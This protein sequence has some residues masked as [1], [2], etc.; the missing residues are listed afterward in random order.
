MWRPP[1]GGRSTNKD[2]TARRQSDG[3]DR[4]VGAKRKPHERLVVR[5]DA[6]CSWV[7]ELCNDRAALACSAI[8]CTSS[9]TRSR[10]RRENRRRD[11]ASLGWSARASASSG[12][13]RPCADGSFGRVGGNGLSCWGT[14]CRVGGAVRR[15]P[16]SRFVRS[17]RGGAVCRVEGSGGAR[18]DDGSAP[19][20]GREGRPSCSRATSAVIQARVARPR[21]RE[22]RREGRPSSWHLARRAAATATPLSCLWLPP[23]TSMLVKS[24]RRTSATVTSTRSIAT[25]GQSQRATRRG[26]SAASSHGSVPAVRTN[27]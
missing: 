21:R 2:C 10:M 8:M 11:A 16:V 7:R 5:D 26:S 27:V 6:V 9:S 12:E 24:T 23:F 19:C 22:G 1:L 4:P 13:K 14:V 25:S 20:R 15:G 17:C 18:D 3:D